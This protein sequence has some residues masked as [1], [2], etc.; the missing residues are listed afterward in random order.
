MGVTRFKIY[1]ANR[2]ST[3]QSLTRVSADG[4]DDWRYVPSEENPADDISRGLK[5]T[6]PKWE[7]FHNGPAFLWKDESEWP[8][9]DDVTSSYPAQILATS[10]TTPEKEKISTRENWV[11]RVA[12]STNSWRK[13]LRRVAGVVAV[14]KRMM[15]TWRAR[16]G[17]SDEQWA[18]TTGI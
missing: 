14:V 15:A 11:L 18:E 3:I 7:R 17:S 10:V 8:A 1:F 5:P 6:D 13:K 9:Q 4:N 16:K 2:I 12:S